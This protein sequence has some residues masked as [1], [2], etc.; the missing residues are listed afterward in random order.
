[1]IEI[2]NKVPS[3]INNLVNNLVWESLTDSVYHSVSNI[4]YYSIHDFVDNP[5]RTS[6]CNLANQRLRK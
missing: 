5:L 3:S 6:V 1:M 2:R 4:T